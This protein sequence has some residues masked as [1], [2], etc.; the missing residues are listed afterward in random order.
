MRISTA[1]HKR[2]SIALF[3]FVSVLF[4]AAAAPKAEL[5]PRWEAHNPSNTAIIDHSTFAKFLSKYIV[6]NGGVNLIR[7]GEVSEEDAR[8]LDSYVSRLEA[9]EVSD[10]ARDEQQAYWIPGSSPRSNT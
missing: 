9:M 8:S 7:Y 1:P 10:L 5:W 6:E 4:S 3:F 2:Y